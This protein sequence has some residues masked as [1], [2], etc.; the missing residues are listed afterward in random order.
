MVDHGFL[1]AQVYVAIVAEEGSF[2]RAARRLHTTQSF[3]TKRIAKLEQ[4][5]GTKIFDRSG[6]RLKLTPAG[7]A[8][9]PEVQR[10]LRHSER[11]WDLALYSAKINN[12]LIR[13]GY[14]PYA[15]GALLPTLYHLN[16]SDFEAQNVGA[17]GILEPHSE[18][19]SMNTQELIEQVLRGQVQ[20]GLGIQP[21]QDRDLWVEQVACEA[22]CVCVPKNHGLAQRASLSLRDLHGELLLWIPRKLHPA[23]YDQTVEYIEDTGAHPVYQEM[24]SFMHAI[25]MA[26]RGFGLALLPRSASRLSHPGVVF[27]PMADRFLQIQ[28]AMFA[29]RDL[30]HGALGNFILFLMSQLQSLKLNLQ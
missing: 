19:E 4:T 28:T 11:A 17:A 7:R 12:G 15:N 22:F 3:V 16:L 6:R 30:M 14:S 27:K 29:R 25:D 21:I 8:L 5:L 24:G 23:F 18:L 2:S 9:L 1:Q 20:V 10:A 13:L 26:S